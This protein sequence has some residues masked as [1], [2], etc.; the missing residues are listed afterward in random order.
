MT[1]N[2]PEG[3]FVFRQGCGGTGKEKNYSFCFSL[4]YYRPYQASNKIPQDRNEAP[5]Q[6][7]TYF[8]NDI[9]SVIP[10]SL[11]PEKIPARA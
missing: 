6:R 7:E 1:I 8:I 2:F 9:H 10:P 5:N 3:L 11:Q 4:P